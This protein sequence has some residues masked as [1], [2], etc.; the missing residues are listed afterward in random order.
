MS[1]PRRAV[2][3]KSYAEFL[4]GSEEEYEDLSSSLDSKHPD[5][6]C[7]NDDLERT[8]S[9]ISSLDTEVSDIEE[10]TEAHPDLA[11]LEVVRWCPPSAAEIG[12]KRLLISERVNKCARLRAEYAAQQNILL[13]VEMQLEEEERLLFEDRA[14]IAPVCNLPQ[15]VLSIIFRIHAI[16]HGQSTWTLMHVCRI[17]RFTALHTPAVWTR[18]KLTRPN[19]ENEK[20]QAASR[21]SEGYEVCSQPRQLER[22]LQRVGSVAPLDL[23]IHIIG[24]ADIYYRDDT[25]SDTHDWPQDLFE[26]FDFTNLQNIKVPSDFD[27]VFVKASMEALDIRAIE[28]D[29]SQIQLLEEKMGNAEEIKISTYDT[30]RRNVPKLVRRFA[31]SLT[32]LTLYGGDFSGVPR[33]EIPSLERL[34]LEY[35]IPS[36]PID[37]PRLKY[38]TLQVRSDVPIGLEVRL[39]HLSH[40]SFYGPTGETLVSFDAPSLHT[41]ELS[42]RG[43]KLPMAS[44]LRKIW[45]DPSKKKSTTRR[46]DPVVFKYNGDVNPK[47]L[48]TVLPR[49]TRCEEFYSRYVDL[50]SEFFWMLSIAIE[51]APPPAF[52]GGGRRNATKDAGGGSGGHRGG[53]K[54]S[55]A[56]Q[57]SGPLSSLRKL[58]GDL[59]FQKKVN[60]SELRR[61]VND[62]V[63]R[64]KKTRVPMEELSLRYQGVGWKDFLKEDPEEMGM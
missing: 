58:V 19:G 45:P 55:K 54:L 37:C 57:R 59:S 32:A 51:T 48:A 43:D 46:F 62:F 10:S 41:L 47:A 64:K 33:V 40:I 20:Y 50:N 8:S 24:D 13:Q 7:G 18:I 36:W 5:T 60:E 31:H 27:S 12:E 2:A 25:Q 17:W 22:A 34:E 39:P 42:L 61:R 56:A 15:D 6:L 11:D 53:S 38:L 49:M 1:R 35:V 9:R 14:S 63:A 52:N 16:E 26:A 21:I 4:S 3:T 28:G 23:W 30:Q 44:A 29:L